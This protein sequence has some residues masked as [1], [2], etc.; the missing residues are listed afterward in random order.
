MDCSRCH[1]TYVA[2]MAKS[3][4]VVNAHA[5]K[6][7]LAKCTDC[8]PA[9]VLQE[10]HQGVK[11]GEVPL[12]DLR[13]PNDFCLKCHGDYAAL[14]K[15]T[16]NSTAFITPSGESINPHLQ[17]TDTHDTSVECWRCH[18]FHAAFEPISYCYDC[19]HTKEL[20]C[21]KCHGPEGGTWG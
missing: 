20:I 15:L 18:R 10:A 19:H 12:S 17:P 4:L 16:A 6:A 9:S 3:A 7:G 5:V 8:H 14:A 21:S 11:P 1:A 13:F 2:S